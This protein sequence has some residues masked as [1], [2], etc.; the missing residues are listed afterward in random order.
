MTRLNSVEIG[1]RDS[2]TTSSTAWRNDEPARRALA[3]SVIVSGSCLLNALEAAALAAAEPEARQQEADEGA[4]DQRERRP[5]RR[6]AEREDDEQERNA[7]DRCA[8][9]GEELGR[10]ELEVGAGELAGE[11]RPEV[12][13]LDDPVE[14]GEGD[15]LLDAA[16]R[17]RPGPRIRRALPLALAEA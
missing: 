15:A 12:A 3:R 11:V 7:D 4:D 8:P 9:D 16:R 17:C 14:L 6:Q 13:L 10:L 2:R 1:G 5:Q